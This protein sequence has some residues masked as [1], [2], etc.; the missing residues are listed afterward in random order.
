MM[1]AFALCF[2]ML[3]VGCSSSSNAASVATDD[4]GSS[5]P[6]DAGHGAKDARDAGEQMEAGL[7]CSPHVVTTDAGKHDA[8][9]DASNDAG[10]DAK[11]ATPGD[12]DSGPIHCTGD[13]DCSPGEVCDT[14]S[15]A[16]LTNGGDAGVSQCASPPD[17]GGAPGT[18]T[19]NPNDMCCGS[20]SGCVLDPARVDAGPPTIVPPPDSCCPGSAGD[21]YCQGKLSTDT[22]TC[23]GNVCTT[24]LLTC[25]T[26]S[27]AAY[28]KFL[29]Y[30]L[31]DCGCT[32]NGACYS[33]CRTATSSD[34]SSACGTCLAAQ[35]TEGLSST[36]TLTAAEDCGNDPECTA[37]QACAGAC[38]M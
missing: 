20:A 13:V 25:M 31:T 35:T 16:C 33:A 4:G 18:C 5:K 1:R 17:G 37:Y 7:V 6:E 12:A 11:D 32:A 9:K 28:E 26:A 36:C 24:C 14:S 3:A 34:P 22:A 30:Q 8:A 15:H 29:A 27:P 38:P 23:T 21:T 2:L 19:V 10:A